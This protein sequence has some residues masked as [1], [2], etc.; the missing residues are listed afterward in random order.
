MSRRLTAITFGSNVNGALGRMPLG[1]YESKLG[2][3]TVSES[4]VHA[5][6]GWGHS[7]LVTA[8]GQALIFGRGIDGR[9][10][11]RFGKVVFFVYI[12]IYA[13][14]KCQKKNVFFR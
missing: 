3:V 5:S 10:T 11:L 12:Y 2:P 13:Q 14:R 8:D 6:A 1:G 4:I 9:N 7:V